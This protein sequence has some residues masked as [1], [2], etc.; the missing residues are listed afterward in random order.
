MKRN[1]TTVVLV[2]F[3]GGIIGRGFRYLL[4]VVIARGLGAG[5]LGTFAFGLVVLKLLS[6]FAKSG[7]DNAAL[8]YVPRYRSE[9][10][11]QHI[12]GLTIVALVFPLVIG[13]FLILGLTAARP[14]L[15]PVFDSRL[16]ETLP[17]FALGIP[18]FSAMFI[19]MAVS[20]GYNESKYAVYTRDLGQSV[21]ALGLVAI[22]AYLLV[23]FEAVVG[24]YIIS[25]ACGLGL[26]VWFLRKQG[27]LRTDISPKFELKEWFTFAVPMAAIAVANY[28]MSWTDVLMLGA[29]VTP[30]ELGWYQAAY[31]TSVL[32]L[33]VLQSSNSIFPS[34]A[35]GLYDDGKLQR[36]ESIHGVITKWILYLTGLGGIY[37]FLYRSEVLRLF[38]ETAPE[39]E[40]ALVILA[41]GQ[42]ITASVGSSG[43]LLTM[44]GYERLNLL[45]TVVTVLLNVGLNYVLIQQYGI[46]GAG[47]A[48]AVSLSVYN[49]GQL[50]EV[51]FI[52]DIF[53]YNRSYWRGAIGFAVGVGLLLAGRLVP[54]FP[55]GKA[56][57]AGFVALLGFG[58]TTWLL[59]FD[60]Y[61][62]LLIESLD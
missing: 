53:P 25:L 46:I 43:Y 6:V 8:K 56:L 28:L 23:D 9:G 34:L 13:G 37:L 22:G 55:L 31:Q 3:L 20:R 2:A 16:L 7:L 24:G 59:G 15:T 51:Y 48:T 30:E 18:I 41:A 58:V 10:D 61:D 39:A 5:A 4:N 45:N 40:T 32:L 52:L 47:M 1:I 62:R 36:L 29:F 50:A 57:V 12:L 26:V 42:F 14:F 60:Q 49:L 35:S 19:G 38:G 21:V 44:S 17:L 54:L 11:S 33:V 27:A